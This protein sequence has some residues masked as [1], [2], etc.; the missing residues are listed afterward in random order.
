MSPQ[1]R[2]AM[3]GFPEGTTEAMAH[4]LLAGDRGTIMGVVFP[5]HPTR[6]QPREGNSERTSSSLHGCV[7]TANIV[8][9]HGRGTTLP[10]PSEV[11]NASNLNVRHNERS[12]RP[13]QYLQESDGA[14]RVPGP[15]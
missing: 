9:V 8:P 10:S 7:G 14:T 2:T 12:C 11:Q 15:C 5:G 13:P 4:P 6:A 1:E 3:R